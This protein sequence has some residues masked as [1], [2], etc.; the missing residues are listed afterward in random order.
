LQ[1]INQADLA[2]ALKRCETEPIHRL[3]LIQPHGALIVFNRKAPFRVEQ[4]SANLSQFFPVEIDQILGAPLRDLLGSEQSAEIASLLG[5]CTDN[6][7]LFTRVYAVI[8]DDILELQVSVRPQGE[9]CFLEFEPVALDFQP[10]ETLGMF[11][12]VNKATCVLDTIDNVP[13]YCQVVA[14]LVRDLIRFDRVMIYRFD[15]RWDGEVIAESRHADKDSYLGNRFPA[16]DIPPQARQL[17]IQNLLRVVSDVEATPVTMRTV[18]GVPAEPP[19]DL[20]LTV[21]RAFSPVHVEYLKNMGVRASLSISIILDGKLWGLIA[22]HHDAPMRVAHPAREMLRFVGKLIGMKLSAIDAQQQ[23]IQGNQLGEILTTLIRD[24]YS[25]EDYLQAVKDYAPK[26]LALLDA[27]GAAVLIDGQ[28]HPLGQVP[29]AGRLEALLDWLAG[30]NSQASLATN[31]LAACYPP[32]ADFPELAAGL[33]ATGFSAGGRNGM[34]WFRAE[35]LRTIHWAGRPDKQLETD[36]HGE[37]R[38]SPRKS[39]AVWQETWRQRS[40]DWSAQAISAGEVLAQALIEAMVQKG[41]K[42][43]DEFYRLFGDQTPEM[44]AR[45]APDGRF[46]YVSPTSSMVLGKRPA[47]LLGCRMQDLI[48]AA[49]RADFV[50][51]LSEASEAMS[52]AVFRL[53]TSNSQHSWLEISIKRVTKADGSSELIAI[54]RDVTERQ[55][56]LLAV[57]EFQHVNQRL[58]EAEG[59]G[60]V[61]VDRAGDV[62]YANPVACDLLGWPLAE[63]I[64]R[65]G[66][67]LIHHSR[68]DGSPFPLEECPTAMV[69]KS[70][71]P[72][73]CH[74]DYYFH[75]S[76]TALRVATATTPIINQGEI[77]GALA[78][79]INAMHPDGDNPL[80]ANDQIGAIMTLDREGRITSFSDSLARLT[81]YSL[82]ESV[83]QFPSLLQSNVHTRSFF[84][85]LWQTLQREKHWQGLIWNRCQDSSIR[86]FWVSMNAVCD[87][88]GEIDQ[89][90]VIYGETTPKSSPEAQLQF[91]ASHDNLTGLPNRAN[92]S[93]RLRQAIAR[94]TRLGSMLALAFI[95]MDRFK[96]INDSFG[97]AVGDAYLVEVARRLGANCREEDTIARW[98]GDEFIL[99]MEDV[100]QAD[101]PLL[102]TQRLVAAL[103]EPMKLDEK[104]LTV[105]ASVGLAIFPAD[106]QT[107]A[108]L[109]QAADQAMY[110][111]KTQPDQRIV[112]FR[113]LAD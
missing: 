3:G 91:L 61:A 76:G 69:L 17:Y 98:G 78:V 109:I 82:D 84:R 53:P 111:A 70:G 49:D 68:P 79:F 99:L 28:I 94:S 11:E 90:V 62:V 33:L 13:D 16:G 51:L 102:F 74:D 1:Q 56:F 4:A 29:D 77:T 100:Q 42:Q 47:E 50:Q 113:D 41:L 81:G 67:Q 75:R 23:L 86:P 60:V 64:G 106:G 43:R 39:F 72:S 89:Y 38:I 5:R 104:T 101:Y 65:N 20:S 108:S 57:E 92:L 45:H 30:Q 110:Q 19:L 10:S 24:V 54:S 36:G 80:I 83:G 7:A 52:S 14:D 105:S 87:R 9:V 6:N 66:H 26:I 71:K 22:C 103:C 93:R 37:W 15:A 21:L 25:R 85:E 58:L 2:Q 18:A 95:D 31:H 48:D 96:Q 55:K 46:T 97:H 35:R 27:S 112:S 40:D 8:N 88:R 73:L 59:E 32:A 12:R 44:I 34:L 63:L 107:A